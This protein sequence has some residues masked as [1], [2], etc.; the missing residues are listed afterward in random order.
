MD[1]IGYNSFLRLSVHMGPPNARVE[2]I[3][4][5]PSFYCG[6][7]SYRSNRGDSKG[8]TEA[9]EFWSTVS[10]STLQIRHAAVYQKIFQS[11]VLFEESR[12]ASFKVARGRG[13]S[14][15]TVFGLVNFAAVTYWIERSGGPRIPDWMAEHGWAVGALRLRWWASIGHW[16]ET[17]SNHRSL[18]QQQRLT[19]DLA[20]RGDIY[21][22]GISL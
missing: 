20:P 18:N 16:G 19:G 22:R 6:T 8:A 14:A 1:S 13:I 21:G 17:F 10:L 5:V 12:G 2:T 3:L 7:S 9:C 11:Y 15:F 4:W